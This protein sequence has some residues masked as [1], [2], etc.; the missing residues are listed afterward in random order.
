M[1]A[2][3]GHALVAGGVPALIAAMGVHPPG[4]HVRLANGEVAVVARRLTDPK[5][6]V[7]YA[8]CDAA[9]RACQPARKRLTASQPQFAI[10]GVVER[11]TV[12]VPV[13]VEDL[14]PPLQLAAR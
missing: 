8:L 4:T 11:A 3:H 9:G 2:R 14:W 10:T 12:S 5:F 6:P 7:V 1:H 13:P